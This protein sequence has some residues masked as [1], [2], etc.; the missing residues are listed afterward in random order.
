VYYRQLRLTVFSYIADVGEVGDD[1]GIDFPDDGA[2]GDD[3]GHIIGCGGVVNIG[4][5]GH[6]AHFVYFVYFGNIGMV[7]MLMKLVDSI[8]FLKFVLEIMVVVVLVVLCLLLIYIIG[9]NCGD[10]LMF[11]LLICFGCG[12]VDAVSGVGNDCVVGSIGDGDVSVV[13]DVGYDSVIAGVGY[14]DD[15]NVE[16]VDDADCIHFLYGHDDDYELYCVIGCGDVGHGGHVGPFIL[17]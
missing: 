5:V 2:V 7:V 10:F 9:I 3:L 8:K 16:N 13:C 14:I 12:V 6:V 1:D 15:D 11:V 4:H 17:F